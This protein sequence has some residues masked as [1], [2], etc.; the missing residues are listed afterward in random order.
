MPS[1][2]VVKPLSD[3]APFNAVSGAHVL[4]ALH[5]TCFPQP[6]DAAAISALTEQILRPTDPEKPAFRSAHDI[7]TGIGKRVVREY[8]GGEAG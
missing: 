2:P 7:L 5:A 8:T 6:W 1:C 3:I 4:A